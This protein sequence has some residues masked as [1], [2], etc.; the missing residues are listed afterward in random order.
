ML[1]HDIMCTHEVQSEVLSR[2]HYQ[3]AWLGSTCML[4]EHVVVD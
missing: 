1:W 2:L 3:F 4:I